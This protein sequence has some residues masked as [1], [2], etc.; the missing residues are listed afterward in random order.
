MK[1]IIDESN[2]ESPLSTGQ[3]TLRLSLGI[4]LLTL[5][6]AMGTTL[7]ANINLGTGTSE[8]G[9]GV[10]VTTACDNLITVTPVSSFNNSATPSPAP[11]PGNVTGVFYLGSIRVSDVDSSPSGCDGKWLTLKSFDSTNSTP[12]QLID[13]ALSFSVLNTSGV[14]S[15]TQSG[16][17]VT[18]NSSSSFT[19]SFTAPVALS[20]EVTR[21]TLETSNTLPDQMLVTY[22]VGDI[23]PGGGRIFYVNTNGFN[24]GTTFS[25]TGSP[26]GGLCKYLEVALNSW[27]GDS[28]TPVDP[29]RQLIVSSGLRNDNPDIVNEAT[30]YNNAASIGL[31]YKNTLA[32]IQVENNA[33]NA[34]GSARAFTGGGKTDWYLPATSE[35]N[36]LCQWARGVT[37]NVSIKC[38]GGN[39]N[40]IW[41][42]NLGI[43]TGASNPVSFNGEKAYWSSS[44]DSGLAWAQYF[45]SSGNQDLN[46]RGDGNNV[47]PIR[48]F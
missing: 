2:T 16:F 7:A 19:I 11:T 43:T 35:L 20:S 3:K 28:G 23:G 45:N 44:E 14:F 26:T 39:D 17:T 10:Q 27:D 40:R 31:G 29:R 46:A 41:D 36:L 15:S 42:I 1:S 33:S 34:A 18:T 30:A 8:F 24:C 25:S 5:L 48:A 12:L 47:R 37:Q 4:G 38:S 9:Q 22:A 6:Y 13:G 32:I 21:V